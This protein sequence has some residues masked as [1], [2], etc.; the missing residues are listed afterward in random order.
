M[1]REIL[2]ESPIAALTFGQNSLLLIMSVIEAQLA[3]RPQTVH[4]RWPDA[5][6]GFAAPSTRLF[7]GVEVRNMATVQSYYHH[8]KAGMFSMWQII[9]KILTICPKSTISSGEERALRVRFTPVTA[10]VRR[11]CRAIAVALPLGETF[12]RGAAV[13]SEQQWV[14]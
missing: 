9:R 2:L 12:A 5:A 13:G 7:L 11:I 4:R 1:D 8:E 10:S 3:M 14:S 6:R